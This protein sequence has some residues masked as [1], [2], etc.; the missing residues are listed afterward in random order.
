MSSLLQL[1]GEVFGSVYAEKL[2][3]KT[4]YSEYSDILLNTKIDLK[5]LDLNFVKTPI[6]KNNLTKDYAIV[7]EL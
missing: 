5:G 3:L 6:F 2:F 1:K 7:K 4:E